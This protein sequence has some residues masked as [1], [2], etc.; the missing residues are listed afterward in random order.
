M[1]SMR[2]ALLIAA[3]VAALVACGVLWIALSH[4]PQQEF[5]GSEL[6][7]NWGGV[8]TLCGASFAVAFTIL[9]A[10]AWVITKVAQAMAG[11]K[12]RAQAS[13]LQ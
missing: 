9:A 8:T 5:Y 3:G 13:E 12:A 7:V 1:K 4:N 2:R 11:S 6:G 10:L